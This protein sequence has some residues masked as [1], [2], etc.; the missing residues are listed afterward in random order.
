MGNSTDGY[1]LVECLYRSPKVRLEIGNRA[2]PNIRHWPPHRHWR[3]VSYSRYDRSGPMRKSSVPAF[4]EHFARLLD[5]AAIVGVIIAIGGLASVAWLRF[6]PSDKFWVVVAF[7]LIAAAIG[8]LVGTFSE[9]VANVTRRLSRTRRV[10]LSYSF[11]ENEDAGRLVADRL[12]KAGVRVWDSRSLRPGSAWEP[13]VKAAIDQANAFV[14]LLSARQTQHIRREI[15]IARRKGVKILPVMT[16]LGD[17]SSIDPFIARLALIDLQ[18]DKEQALH[19]L[20]E[21]VTSA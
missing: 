17:A 15:E 3:T 14:L 5:E 2:I 21:A 18:K 6:W 19:K 16:G 4:V 7:S 8:F 1:R 10:F 20:V 13:Q 9:S 11:K 12:R